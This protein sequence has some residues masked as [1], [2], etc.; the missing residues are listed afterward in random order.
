MKCVLLAIGP[1]RLLLG[2]VLDRPFLQHTVE[3]LIAR[4]VRSIR[5]L[6]PQS[7]REISR[8][9]GDGSR[10]GIDIEYTTT[11]GEP[12][13]QDISSISEANGNDLILAGRADC[14]PFFP[15]FC[16]S[17]EG[18]EEAGPAIYFEEDGLRSRWNGWV[19]LPGTDCAAFARGLTA[20]NDWRE[21][22]RSEGVRA[23]KV[24]LSR[25]GL[26]CASEKDLLGSNRAALDGS[27]P[28]LF[29]NGRQVQPGVWM[30]RAARIPDS[31]TIHAPCYIGEESWIEGGCTLGPHAVIGPRC[32]ISR[33][34]AITRSILT[35]ST[36]LGPEL[37]VAD[38]LVNRTRVHNVRLGAEIEIEERHVACDLSEKSSRPWWPF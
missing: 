4:G 27:F 30:A 1:S 9:L 23:R 29:F 5:I 14:L 35:E 15:G 17:D 11:G 7:D 18:H 34:T 13:W 16:G 8:L 24:F 10:W 26:S 37:E 22:L 19:L 12:G 6:L 20:G 21:A 32:L 25:Q 31:V 3:Q 2:Q 36:F 38:S 28:N 33:G